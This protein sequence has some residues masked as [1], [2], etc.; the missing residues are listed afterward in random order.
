MAL[1]IIEIRVRTIK[2]I[3]ILLEFTLF[4][5][6]VIR[7]QCRHRYRDANDSRLENGGDVAE[8]HTYVFPMNGLYC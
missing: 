3:R 2:D 5:T 4:L 7:L 1:S 8:K 6:V